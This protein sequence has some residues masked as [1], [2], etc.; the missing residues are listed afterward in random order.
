M[1]IYELAQQIDEHMIRLWLKGAPLQEVKDLLAAGR[2][3]VEM[4]EEFQPKRKPRSDKGK[5][6]TDQTSLLEESR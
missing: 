5:S 4:R 3:I 1:Y 2:V 6:R